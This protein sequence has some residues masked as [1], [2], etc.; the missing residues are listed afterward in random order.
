M[1][2][3]LNLSKNIDFIL[4]IFTT[5]SSCFTIIASI[6]ASL[7]KNEDTDQIKGL[8]NSI[9][10][11]KE[12]KTIFFRNPR[13]FPLETFY[14]QEQMKLD[15]ELQKGINTFKEENYVTLLDFIINLS[16]SDSNLDD[17]SSIKKE[18]IDTYKVQIVQSMIR[19]VFSKDKYY[20]FSNEKVKKSRIQI[21]QKPSEI[22][23]YYEYNFL[24]R[25][26][27]KSVY[28]SKTGDS[29]KDERIFENDTIFNDILNNIFFLFGNDTL[30]RSYV[31]PLKKLLSRCEEKEEGLNI[32]N[33]SRFITDLLFSLKRTLPYILKIILKLS[34]SICQEILSISPLDF[35][36]IYSLLFFSFI[37][38][39]RVQ[40]MFEIKV[41][42]I[43]NLLTVEKI[44]KY[45]CL[46]KTFKEND[47][48][49]N[50]NNLI[51]QYNQ[52]LKSFIIENIIP[53]SEKRKDVKDYLQCL[54]L[55][56]E[57]QIPKLLFYI[58]CNNVIKIVSGGKNYNYIYE[59]VK[60]E[61]N[62]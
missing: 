33:V 28:S 23:S 10:L 40:T 58:D 35:T 16:F 45:I 29:L 5:T 21:K 61:K 48:Y 55:N 38:S 47:E 42:N 8:I 39:P 17:D 60:E 15:Q 51:L 2:L 32:I 30:Y 31:I 24:E 22:Y 50:F 11:Q 6:G 12:Y 27:Y 57:I 13:S 25:L 49:S 26:I 53:I 37:L 44:I 59:T 3:I 4:N 20:Y 34:F 41:N 46:K 18:F 7:P 14:T 1:I 62:K 43:N 19:I 56:K 36:P 54:A 9:F 52:R